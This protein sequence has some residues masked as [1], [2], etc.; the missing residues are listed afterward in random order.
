[1]DL[2]TKN[3]AKVAAKNGRVTGVGIYSSGDN[4]EESTEKHPWTGSFRHKPAKETIIFALFQFA[5]KLF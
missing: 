3:L 2:D 4:L 1:M 5:K